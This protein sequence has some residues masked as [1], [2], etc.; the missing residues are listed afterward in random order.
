MAGETVKTTALTNAQAGK[1]REAR[2]NGT[3]YK[4][5]T[6]SKALL[7]TETETA[8]VL[9]TNIRIPSN[10]IVREIKVYNDDLDGGSALTADVGVAAAVAFTSVTSGTKTKHAVDDVLDADVFVDGSTALQAATTS[11]TSLPLD[12]GTSGPDDIDK[13]VWE[14][15]GYDEDPST[16]VVI[17]VTFAAGAG[18][19]A[20]GDLAIQ[21]HYLVD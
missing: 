21:V 15:L 7:S 8:D 11:F 19:P 20:A 2:L 14:R 18:T 16:D 9:L 1:A 12:A 3:A 13:P 4:V 17:A 5:A 6:D 10:A